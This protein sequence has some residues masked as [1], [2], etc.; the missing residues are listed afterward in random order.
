MC[1]WAVFL[2]YMPDESGAYGQNDVCGRKEARPSE[3]SGLLAPRNC[4][5]GYPNSGPATPFLFNRLPFLALCSLPGLF[6]LVKRKNPQVT[7]T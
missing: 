4:Q 2:L 1:L 5:K 6:L 7:K 3:L